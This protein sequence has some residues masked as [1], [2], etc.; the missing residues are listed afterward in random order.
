MDEGEHPNCLA[1]GFV[2]KTIIPMRDKLARAR[3]VRAW[4]KCRDGPAALK[5]SLQIFS[6]P[7]EPFRRL[8]AS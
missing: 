7:R 4:G 3:G 1:A 2:D 6:N 5:R 8:A